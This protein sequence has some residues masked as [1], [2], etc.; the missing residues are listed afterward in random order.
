MVGL[1]VAAVMLVLGAVG[2]H[3]APYDPLAQDFEML[4][5]PS[6]A[7]PFG[8]DTFGRDLLSQVLYGARVSLVVGVGAS[9]LAMLFGVVLGLIAGFYGGWIDDLVGRY[10]DLQWAFPQVILALALVTIF[11][12]GLQNVIIAIAIAFTDDFARIVRGEVLR[13]REEEFVLA[14]RV[15]G[16]RDR[17]IMFGEVLP[18]AVGPAIVQ[19]AVS[20]G[21]GILTEATLTFLGLGVDPSTPTWGVILYESR[22]FIQQAWWISV[23][24]GLAI[25]LTVLSF[26]LV[27]D[28]L[29][30]AL[31]VRAMEVT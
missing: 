26:N 14:A 6:L 10:I 13:L 12:I 19:F 3:I 8:T 31:N 1:V 15:V 27:G 5:P 16:M 2:P 29:R 25:M 17:L 11:G 30:D 7:H 20:I 22:S 24:P 23:F 21:L 4:E 28:G 18:N 9:L